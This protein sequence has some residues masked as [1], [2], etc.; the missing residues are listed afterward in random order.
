MLWPPKLV[1]GFANGWTVDPA[2]V[3]GAIHDGTLAVT[4]VWAPQQTVNIALVISALGLVLCLGLVLLPRRRRRAQ[5]DPAYA[6]G[7]ADDGPELVPAW[8]GRG[9]PT[10]WPAT[11]ATALG[12]GLA[13]AYISAPLTGVLVGAGVAVVLRLPRLRLVLGTVATGLILIMGTFVVVR[14]GVDPTRANGGWPS[15][16]GGADGLAWA[17]VLFL[18]ADAV[19]ELVT[20]KRSGDPIAV[21]A[22]AVDAD[23]DADDDDGA[24]PSGGHGTVVSD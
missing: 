2:S 7:T 11:V 19:V 18:G 8:S 24:A 12:C 20:R 23:A 4:M 10:R 1:D 21:P 9:D 3:A 17:G 15:Q 14:Q 13:A 22:I 5:T 16:F 6:D